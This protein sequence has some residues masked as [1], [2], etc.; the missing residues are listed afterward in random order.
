MSMKGGDPDVWTVVAFVLFVVVIV[1]LL[2][3]SR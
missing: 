2:M 1:L 3:T